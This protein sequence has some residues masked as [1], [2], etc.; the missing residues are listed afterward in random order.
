[1]AEYY[2]QNIIKEHYMAWKKWYIVWNNKTWNEEKCSE[3]K[4]K[5][6]SKHLAV[7]LVKVTNFELS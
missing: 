6:R 3:M 4:M 1:M 5:H 2:H 7:R